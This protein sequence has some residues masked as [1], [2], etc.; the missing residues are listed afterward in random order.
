MYRFTAITALCLCTYTGQAQNLSR[1]HIDAFVG[2]VDYKIDGYR[3][4]EEGF[5]QFRL[6]PA[7]Q[8]HASWRFSK[9]WALGIHQAF[10]TF[11]KTYTYRQDLKETFYGSRYILQ[12]SLSFHYLT[13][14]KNQLYSTL[15]FGQIWNLGKNDPGSE[16]FQGGTSN[17]NVQLILLGYKHF[18][19]KKLGFLSELAIGTPTALNL[20]FCLAIP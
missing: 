1:F 17:D 12:G 15:R 20:G 11:K 9:R 7:Y 5:T 8:I 19:W 4:Q 14:E 3:H 10:T 2:A 13:H 6:S 18:F 16:L